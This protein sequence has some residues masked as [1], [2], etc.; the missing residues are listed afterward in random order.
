MASP[1]VD[2]RISAL[3]ARLAGLERLLEERLPE[4]LPAKDSPKRG[5]QAIVGTFAHDPLHEEAMRLGRE[6]R[7]SQHS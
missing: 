2:N 1:T 7:E 4:Q 5:W 6:L 3:E